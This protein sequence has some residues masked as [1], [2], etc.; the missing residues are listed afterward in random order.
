MHDLIGVEV[1]Y[2]DKI[3]RDL[4]LQKPLP[5]SSGFPQAPW[6]NIGSLVNRGFE[7]AVRAV[8][9]NKPS[10]SWDIRLGANTLHNEVTDMG[11]IAPFGT[12]NRVQKGLQLGSWWTRKIISVDT[13]TGVVRV[14]ETPVVAG[15]VL[16]TFEGNFSTNVTV[17]R[18]VRFYGLID[19]KRGHKVRNFTD[20]F[21]ET[22]LVRSN[23][24]LDTTVLT[25]ME[26]LRRYGNPNVG[27]PAFL[28]PLDSAKTVN[29][30]QEDYIQDG[31]FIRLRELSLS[32]T[33]PAQWAR[34]FRAT[35]ATVTLAGQNLALW[36]K[37]QG[38]DPEVVSNAVALYNRDDFFTQPPV[39]RYVLRVNFTF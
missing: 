33:I 14:T 26:R 24:R 9:V 27:Q 5:P 19:T 39:R 18:N 23:A 25:K 28:T 6:V 8:P 13:T 20:F 34:L 3:S 4:L 1:T 36:T 21:R 2:F 15:N 17:L 29:D 38:Y 35:T 30:V 12:L 31:T 37:Y 11:A 10:V 16:P 22:Q 32:Y 7:L